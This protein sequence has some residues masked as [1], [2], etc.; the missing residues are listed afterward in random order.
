VFLPAIMTEF[1]DEE[2]AILQTRVL[3][4]VVKGKYIGRRVNGRPSVRMVSR[5]KKRQVTLYA[6]HVVLVMHGKI[7]REDEQASHLC[8]NAACIDIDHLVWESS[9][10]NMRRRKCMAR[11]KCIC[12]LTPQC[13]F[14]NCK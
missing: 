1:N 2:R 12:G 6:A 5:F 11:G 7:P 3:R 8:H 4:N 9:D 13:I 10:R 14:C